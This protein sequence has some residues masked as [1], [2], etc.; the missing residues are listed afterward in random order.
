MPSWPQWP[1]IGIEQTSIVLPRI[2]YDLPC[3]LLLLRR[4]VYAPRCTGPILRACILVVTGLSGDC[5]FD[6]LLMVHSRHRA[7]THQPG[8]HT[9]RAHFLVNAA[10]VLARLWVVT[11]TIAFNFA[12]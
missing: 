5:G 9:R 6:R 11:G 2:I 8:H 1:C 10:S 4:C 7:E 3:L 12:P